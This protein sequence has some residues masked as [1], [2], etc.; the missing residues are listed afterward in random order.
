MKCSLRPK[1]R[2]R[3]TKLWPGSTTRLEHRGF[4]IEEEQFNSSFDAALQEL[5]QTAA[6]EKGEPKAKANPVYAN[7]AGRLDRSIF[8]GYE[9]T[10]VDDATVVAL[11]KTDE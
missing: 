8:K 2:C 3:N 11:I 1:E 4:A 9:T 7:L 10:R 5:Q 6:T